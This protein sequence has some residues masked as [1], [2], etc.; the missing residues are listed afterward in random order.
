M[1]HGNFRAFLQFLFYATT[2][3]CHAL[4]L[5]A[6]HAVHAVGAATSN[7]VLRTGPQA[8]VSHAV[9]RAR[10][11]GLFNIV[12]DDRHLLRAGL[13][14]LAAHSLPVVGGRQRQSTFCEPGPRPQ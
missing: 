14:A 10:S 1:G 5:L 13:L 4:G 3:A 11:D 2:A 7:H 6:A 12:S 9:I 8:R